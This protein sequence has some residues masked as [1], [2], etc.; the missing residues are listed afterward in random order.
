MPMI[1]IG[2]IQNK[3][4]FQIR[5]VTS[6]SPMIDNAVRVVYWPSTGSAG[7]GTRSSERPTAITASGPN[8]RSGTS[9]AARTP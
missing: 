6:L 4:I 9:F 7:S 3:S 8:S 5:M 2:V 1:V